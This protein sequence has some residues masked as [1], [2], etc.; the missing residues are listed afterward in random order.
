MAFCKQRFHAV[1][2]CIERGYLFIYTLNR[3]PWETFYLL[4]VEWGERCKLNIV[5]KY[6][7]NYFIVYEKQQ[8]KRKEK[9]P[10]ICLSIFRFWPNAKIAKNH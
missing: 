7:S 1:I 8:Y 6:L 3:V 2:E 5:I 9:N 10:F 4:G